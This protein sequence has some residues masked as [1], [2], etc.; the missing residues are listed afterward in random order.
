MKNQELYD[1][2]CR[3]MTWYEHPEEYPL[4]DDDFNR[5]ISNEMYEVL[6]KVLNEM[7]YN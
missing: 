2:V 3:V 5:N 1:E 7:F 4:G 6:S